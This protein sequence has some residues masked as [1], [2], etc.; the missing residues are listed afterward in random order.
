M[1]STVVNVYVVEIMDGSVMFDSNYELC[2]VNTIA[3]SDIL[4]GPDAPT[5]TY[6]PSDPS[7]PTR[8]CK[9][10]LLTQHNF[11]AKISQVVKIL[12]HFV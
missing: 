11:H 8:Q 6:T 10:V 3:W 7:Q 2:Y 1:L 4:T 12:L 9:Y 5:T